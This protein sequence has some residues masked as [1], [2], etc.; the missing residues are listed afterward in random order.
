MSLSNEISGRFTPVI[1]KVKQADHVPL[2]LVVRM[3]IDAHMFTADCESMEALTAAH[4][5]Q[6]VESV[7]V[8][9]RLRPA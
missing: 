9:E 4:N 5:D 2:G 7:T 1:V 8:S 6:L 3:R